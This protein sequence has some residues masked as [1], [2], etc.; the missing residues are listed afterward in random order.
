MGGQGKDNAYNTCNPIAATT[1]ITGVIM[2]TVMTLVIKVL[3]ETYSLNSIGQIVPF[4]KPLTTT[5]A[6]FLG[7][8]CALPLHF[9]HQYFLV[10]KED[11]NVDFPLWV[12][13]LFLVPS[14]FDLIGTAFAKVGLLYVTVSVFQLL[15]ATM[16]IFT[17]VA[18]YF[19][20]NDVIT[21]YMWTGVAINTVAMVLVGSTALFMPA[22]IGNKSGREPIWGVL[23]ILCS[24]A[25]NAMQYVVEEKFLQIKVNGNT[26]PPLLVVGMEGFY[27]SIM[28]VGVLY[29]A[30]KLP[31]EDPSCDC[32]ENVFDSWTMY[33][34]SELARW[35]LWGFIIS[36]GL[37]NIFCIFVTKFLSAI[38][39]SIL[40]NFRPGSVWGSDLLLYIAT[41][42]RF[43]EAWFWGSWFEL[44]GMLILFSGTAVYSGYLR[45]PLES[46]QESYLEMEANTREGGEKEDEVGLMISQSPAALRKSPAA[47]DSMAK[48]PRFLKPPKQSQRAPPAYG[49][50][51]QPD[52]LGQSLLEQNPTSAV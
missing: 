3:Y 32:F 40:D 13:V 34:N 49:S 2:G 23:F 31:G 1:F 29:G 14:I 12:Y 6:M 51:N 19:V 17:V 21:K 26:P 37:Y 45:I 28:M 24:C 8:S 16:L 4:E 11:R 10:K 46:Y 47:R 5:L 52:S 48:S 43:G 18:K 38:W 39:H 15:R 50:I 27:G 20:F 9:V 35:M 36:V 30:L 22:D 44:A 33:Q 41:R 25:T 7:M 42:G